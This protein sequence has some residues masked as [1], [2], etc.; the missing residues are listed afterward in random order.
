MMFNSSYYQ[1]II[2]DSLS[3]IKSTLQHIWGN[4][5]CTVASVIDVIKE[6]K[7][8]ENA[9]QLGSYFLL[10]LAK[11]RDEFEIVGDVRGK[12]FM[13]GVELVADKES[14]VTLPAD[15]VGAIFE[16]MKEMRVLNGKVFKP[17]PTFFIL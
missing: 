7:L 10:E 12:G 4:V 8:Q 17:F 9:Q 14:K 5:A 11:L 13:I 15:Q 1:P 3:S 2:V 6:D 16:D